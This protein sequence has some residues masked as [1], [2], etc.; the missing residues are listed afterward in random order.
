MQ[1]CNVKTYL[2]YNAITAEDLDSCKVPELF[3]WI[4]FVNSPL[5]LRAHQFFFL[6]SN[7]IEQGLDVIKKD[8][9]ILVP[10]YLVQNLL[11]AGVVK[12]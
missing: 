10:R 3:I 1:N 12:F 8:P 4:P 2:I 5:D 11:I 9:K 7:L 6:I